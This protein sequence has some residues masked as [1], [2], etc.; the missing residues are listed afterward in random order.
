MW[1][2]LQIILAVSAFAH[3]LTLADV[4]NINLIPIGPLSIAPIAGSLAVPCPGDHNFNWEKIIALKFLLLHLTNIFVNDTDYVHVPVLAVEEAA[5]YVTSKG[6]VKIMN[7]VNKKSSTLDFKGGLV[8]EK[9]D[10]KSDMLNFIV[11]PIKGYYEGYCFDSCGQKTTNGCGNACAG[12][13]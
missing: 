4:M 2:V 13:G 6:G 3:A 7:K 12:K 9:V 11:K 5:I 1:V 10:K 8:V